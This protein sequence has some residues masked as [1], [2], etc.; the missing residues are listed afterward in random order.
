MSALADVQ[1]DVDTRGIRIPAVG[2]A[3]VALP[4]RYR[5]E[6][7]GAIVPVD[8]EACLV[9]DITSERR[10]TRMSRLTD[11]L[12]EGA[13]EPVTAAALLG[14]VDQAIASVGIGTAWGQAA[15]RFRYH[16]A[17]PAPVT[18]V[19]GYVPYDVELRT[20]RRDRER[21]IGW[22]VT[23]PVTTLCPC[24]QSISEHGAH[25]QRCHITISTAFRA[26]KRYPSLG[27]FLTEAE[28]LGSCPLFS[29]LEQTDEKWVTETAWTRPKFVEDV[30]RDVVGWLSGRTD[31]TWFAVRV[32][33]EESI[34][35]HNAIAYYDRAWADPAIVQPPLWAWEPWG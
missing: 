23:V 3:P 5:D 30:L 35:P 10:G 9:T 21:R 22:R 12:A 33:S 19:P 29:S 4:L 6:E 17:K 26:T 15:V 7:T 13:R 2:V 11:V 32:V 18:G 28:R 16:L 8:A 25:N 24:S 14:W 1:D 34:H 31:V 27:A 20:S